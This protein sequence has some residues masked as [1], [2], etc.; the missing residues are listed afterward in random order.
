MNALHVCTMPA[1]YPWGSKEGLDLPELEL[2]MTL[3]Q[4]MGAGN[5]TQVLKRA[6]NALNLWAISLPWSTL[7]FEERSLIGL[8]KPGWAG[9]PQG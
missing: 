4:H 7:T 5:Q 3:S 6:T 2:Q 8:G 9:E 1:W